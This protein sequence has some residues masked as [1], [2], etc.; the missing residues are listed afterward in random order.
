M[1]R[2]RVE[3]TAPL[4]VN[5]FSEKQKLQLLGTQQGR[6]ATR[7]PKNPEQNFDAARYRIDGDTD[8]VPATAFKGSIVDAARYFKGNKNL[9]MTGLKQMIFVKGKG[10]EILVPI[11]GVDKKHEDPVRNANGNADLR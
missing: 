3:G 9:T 10:S 8:G 1:A 7:E 11:V 4:I 6:A 2:I 5:R